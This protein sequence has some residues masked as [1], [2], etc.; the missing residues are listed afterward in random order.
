MCLLA[1]LVS[2]LTLTVHEGVKIS[3]CVCALRVAVP[4]NDQAYPSQFVG[5]SVTLLAKV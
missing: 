1:V 3:L 2:S 4:R 5:M